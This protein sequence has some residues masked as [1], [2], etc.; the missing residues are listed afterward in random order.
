MGLLEK[1]IKELR[2]LRDRFRKGKVD[3][4]AVNCEIAIYS[5]IEKRAKLLLQAHLA[6]AKIDNGTTLKKL[7]KL[8]YMGDG[9]AIDTGEDVELDK[10]KC[11]IREI[12]ITRAE[13]LD[14]SGSKETIDECKGCDI[15]KKTKELLLDR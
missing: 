13:C 14:I 11:P 7:L 10:V 2:D 15:G 8:N 6:C 3:A 1:E 12:I 5:Q 4:H 9:Q